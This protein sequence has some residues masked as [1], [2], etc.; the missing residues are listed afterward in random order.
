MPCTST[1]RRGERSTR[2]RRV[3]ARRRASVPVSACRPGKR[4]IG[5]C[6][7]GAPPGA[8]AC[9]CGAIVST[10]GSRSCTRATAPRARRHQL[11][12][13][14]TPMC[15]PPTVWLRWSY[16]PPA[17]VV[18]AE[19]HQVPL[20]AGMGTTE[21]LSGISRSSLGPSAARRRAPTKHVHPLS[22]FLSC[23]L[24]LHIQI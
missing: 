13:T 4:G 18:P 22:L 10:R 15:H 21:K 2:M 1:E 12:R 6:S 11:L 14:A 19:L 23:Y 7:R 8:A 17:L 16:F 20:L 3:A 24:A 9:W 5:L